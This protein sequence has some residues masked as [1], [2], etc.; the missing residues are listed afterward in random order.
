MFI[1]ELLPFQKCV[2]FCVF[3]PHSIRQDLALWQCTLVLH[4]HSH[5]TCHWTHQT[6]F[7]RSSL[8]VSQ[9][10]SAL[11]PLWIMLP[12]DTHVQEL[13]W[14]NKVF[15][16]CGYLTRCKLQGN[17]ITI[18]WEPVNLLSTAVGER[19][20][21][22]STSTSGTTF[23]TFYFSFQSFYW[24]TVVSQKFWFAIPPRW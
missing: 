18:A 21:F 24:N 2:A 7:M 20:R 4:L 12:T 15:N 3:S 5:T 11:R 13:V 14:M 19:G 1:Q 22:W 8:E 16:S 9:V 6:L 23:A 17:K 10:V